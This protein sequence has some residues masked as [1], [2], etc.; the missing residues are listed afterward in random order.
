MAEDFS[1]DIVSRV[2]FQEVEN[3]LGQV[4]KEIGQ[5]FDFKS[6]PV[7][8]TRDKEKITITAEDEFKMKAVVD[9]LQ[10]KFVKRSVPLK[11]IQYSKPEQALGG[12]VR[13]TLTITS[14]IPT[15]K[16][17]EVVKFIKEKKVKVQ[18]SIQAD[19][20]RVSSKSKDD[21]Q[22]MI[23]LLRDQDFGIDLQFANYR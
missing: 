20:I 16:T 21:L 14:G 6:S 19:Q 9:I 7:T 18:A 1:F 8:I 10:G 4:R 23:K 17:K 11:N 15:E 3:A 22:K 2:D 13:K 12:T 5:R